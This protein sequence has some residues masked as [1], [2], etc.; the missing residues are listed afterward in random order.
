[1]EVVEEEEEENERRFSSQRERETSHLIHHAV[2]RR[3][4]WTHPSGE[5]FPADL[6]SLVMDLAYASSIVLLR[7][8]TQKITEMMENSGLIHLTPANSLFIV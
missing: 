1:M 7:T 4:V 3:R 8:A 6:A 5:K 2:G